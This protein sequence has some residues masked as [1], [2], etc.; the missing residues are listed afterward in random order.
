MKITHVR[1]NMG[2]KGHLSLMMVVLLNLLVAN[3]VDYDTRDGCTLLGAVMGAMHPE[4]L[5][6][7]FIMSIR[8]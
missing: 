6:E 5:Q 1:M 3:P 4:L 2:E 8:I 7:P